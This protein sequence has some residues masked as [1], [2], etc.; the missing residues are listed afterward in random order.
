M[1]ESQAPRLSDGFRAFSA[2]KNAPI[3]ARLLDAL[4][5]GAVP[6]RQAQQ[7]THTTHAREKQKASSAPA[8]RSLAG[9]RP[10]A[11]HTRGFTIHRV[12][13]KH[14]G[15][16]LRCTQSDWRRGALGHSTACGSRG[17]RHCLCC[18]QHDANQ[19]RRLIK[20][21][22]PQTP[23]VYDRHCPDPPRNCIFSVVIFA[24]FAF[25]TSSAL[26]ARALITWLL[27]L[28]LLAS[29]PR[30]HIPY[31]NECIA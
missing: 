22:P 29:S 12:S 8:A 27:L 28:L 18:P 11:A 14:N 10:Y 25:H 21:N 17:A 30:S 23:R 3:A 9:K 31:D 5:P 19:S 24:R 1:Q 13:K 4:H 6:S 16:H 26:R 7:R 15:T 20:Q 2:H